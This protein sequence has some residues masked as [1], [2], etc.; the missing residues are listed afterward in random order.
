MAEE[1]RVSVYPN[2]DVLVMDPDAVDGGARRF[3]VRGQQH[4]LKLTP[5]VKKALNKGMLLPADERNAAIANIKFDRD[6]VA[7]AKAAKPQPN[8]FLSLPAKR[9]GLRRAEA[10]APKQAGQKP[11]ASQ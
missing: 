6:A 5:T 4:D 2:P 7:R 1:R 3:L 10:L 11:E 9:P 8:P